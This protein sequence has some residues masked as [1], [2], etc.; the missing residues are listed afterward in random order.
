[1]GARFWALGIG[2]NLLCRAVLNEFARVQ[3]DDA[4]DDPLGLHRPALACG[5]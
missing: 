1:M 5:Q 3:K 4:V 2:K